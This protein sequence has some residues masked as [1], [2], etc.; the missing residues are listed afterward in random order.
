ML[1]IATVSGQSAH[2]SVTNSH[3]EAAQQALREASYET[4]VEEFR[5]ALR[6]DPTLGAPARLPLA[7]ALIKLNRNGAARDQLEIVRREI[8]DRPDVD[9]YL[10]I[11]SLNDRQFANAVAYL[12]KAAANPPY[13]DTAYQLGFA[14]LKAGDLPC[15]GKWLNVAAKANS[16][17]AQ[18]FYELGL[19]YRQQGRDAQAKQ[20]FDR[21]TALRTAETAELQAEFACRQKLQ[22]G[23]RD[24]ARAACQKLYDPGDARKL[25]QL[26]LAYGKAGDFEAALPPFQRAAELQPNDPRAQYNLALTLCQMKRFDDARQLLS[27]AVKQW[28]NE[29]RIASLYASVL[30]QL[31]EKR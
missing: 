7:G 2:Q 29:S 22:R 11:L 8:G 23:S 15:A 9:Y 28:P 25:I 3:L 27:N 21:S 12:G 6:D 26:G 13:P 31:G 10:G 16:N 1:A 14:C 19:V 4:A 20:A 5:A 17:S 18:A 24:E 30:A